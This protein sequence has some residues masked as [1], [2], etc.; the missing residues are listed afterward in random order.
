MFIDCCSVYAKTEG[1]SILAKNPVKLTKTSDYQLTMFPVALPSDPLIECLRAPS[2]I[3]FPDCLF[4]C[5]MTCD[6]I[7]YDVISG[8]IM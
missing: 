1:F 6:V 4:M 8:F 3:A 5:H 2:F 7:N